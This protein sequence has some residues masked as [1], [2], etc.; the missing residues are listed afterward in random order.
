LLVAEGLVDIDPGKE[1]AVYK[2]DNVK[3][4]KFRK[5][6]KG[7]TEPIPDLEGDDDEY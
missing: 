2:L 6:R 4:R 3:L 7:S 1:Y 5:K